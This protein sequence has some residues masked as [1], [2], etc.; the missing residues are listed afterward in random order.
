[1]IYE[2]RPYQQ[3]TSEFIVAN[4][5]CFPMLDMGL[6]KT[7]STLKAITELLKKGVV[8][9]VLVIAPKK[10]AESVWVQ[11][12]QKWDQFNHLEF[13]LV[14]GSEAQR[15][16]ALHAKADLYVINRENVVWLVSYYAMAFPFDMVV[17]DE[18]SS[19]KNV[20]SARFKA[21]KR[22]RPLIKR[23]VNLTG[24]PTPNG[25][26]QLWPQMY[27][28][29]RGERLG[30]NFFA[31]RRKYF[32]SS[33][34]HGNIDVAFEIKGKRGYEKG[35]G[36]LLGEDLAQKEI[37]EKISDICFSMKSEDYIDLPPK[38]DIEVP[39]LLSQQDMAK[40]FE[41][42][43]NQVLAL[44]DDVDLTAVN[45][46]A[47]TNKLLQFANGAVYH[48]DE[49]GKRSYIEIHDAK[50][51]ALADILDSVN[52]QS[53]LVFY[54][55]K[56]DLERIKHHL[57]AY[58]PRELKTPKDVLDWNQGKAPF[59]LAHPAS[60]G[61]GLN[62]QDGGSISTWFGNTWDLE[63]YQQ[64][65]KRIHRSGQ[66]RPVINNL[67][68]AKGTMDEDVLKSLTAKAGRQ[69]ALI[70]AVKARIKKY[71]G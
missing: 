34:R 64:A 9:K 62:L 17:I 7:A 35:L 70:D 24:T 45:A 20:K 3:H 10:V 23:V 11:E 60:A 4:P 51:S 5:Y 61:H 53:V 68:V 22:I 69:E 58:G 44:K 28:L 54:W 65:N 16:K 48:E 26:L 59:M 18:S 1:M 50:I 36:D 63:L 8:K 32:V 33:K 31:Y 46:A 27:L 42:E 12:G 56:S 6:G 47:L 13:S 55:F 37:Y 21:L 29:D 30:A 67:L 25:L 19:F 14:L 52:G 2:A 40:Y 41:F 38:M 39:V 66:T 43:R 49:A 15:K 71:R 57:R